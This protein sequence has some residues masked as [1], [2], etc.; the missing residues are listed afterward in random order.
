[1]LPTFW[2]VARVRT[3]R[4]R[5]RMGSGREKPDGHGFTVFKGDD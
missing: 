1:V 3:W 5:K 4:Y 2:F